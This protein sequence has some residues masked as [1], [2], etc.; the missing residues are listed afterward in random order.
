MWCSALS[1][2]PSSQATNLEA[3]NQKAPNP[4]F[5]RFAVQTLQPAYGRFMKEVILIQTLNDKILGLRNTKF[6]EFRT[7][8][9][10]NQAGIR[11]HTTRTRTPFRPLFRRDPDGR[12]PGTEVGLSDC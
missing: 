2:P 4:K 10:N 3:F 5:V 12:E 11:I 1:L 8:C 6:S 9:R 7:Y